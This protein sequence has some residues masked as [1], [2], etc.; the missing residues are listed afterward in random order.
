MANSA[1]DARTSE[2]EIRKKMLQAHAVDVMISVGPNFFYTVPL[3]CT[4]WF[5]DKGKKKTD[6]KDK[7]L[8][9]D[10]RHFHH[11]IDKSHREFLPEA[12]RVF[13]QHRP[14]VPW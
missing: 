5:F 6:R 10:A 11:Q 4:L 13:R 12:D 14:A 7:V 3:P 8:F 9:I 2:L 1:A